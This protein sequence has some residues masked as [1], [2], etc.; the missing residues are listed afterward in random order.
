MGFDYAK[1]KAAVTGSPL[2]KNGFGPKEEEKTT[3]TGNSGNL[4][5]VISDVRT[6]GADL[7]KKIHT[8]FD[9]PLVNEIPKINEVADKFNESSPKNT[10][11]NVG[12]IANIATRLTFGTFPSILG[13]LGGQIL[14]NVVRPG[15]Q[16]DQLD[17][18]INKSLD[19]AEKSAVPKKTDPKKAKKKKKEMGP[20]KK[21]DQKKK[22]DY[23][24][25]KDEDGN[26]VK[27]N[28]NT[29]EIIKD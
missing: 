18:Q 16:S 26:V 19:D 25:D 21:Q 22:V 15:K 17:D 20:R 23:Y 12:R 14:E 28:R 3:R 4:K 29:R 2:N 24:Y 11:K 10:V 27:R 9:K 8:G 5:E 7:I 6:K 13:K 1:Y